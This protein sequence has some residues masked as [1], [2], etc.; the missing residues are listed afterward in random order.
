MTLVHQQAG[1]LSI[2]RLHEPKLRCQVFVGQNA[3]DNG[4]TDRDSFSGRH[5]PSRVPDCPQ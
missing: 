4:L 5:L 3:R 2:E 1:N